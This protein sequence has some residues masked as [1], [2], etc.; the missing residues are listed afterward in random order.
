MKGGDYLGE[1]TYGCA[2]TPAPTCK[3]NVEPV[4]KKYVKDKPEL[5]KVFRKDSHTTDEWIQAKA[6]AA[7]DPT[8][9]Y[10]LYATTKCET[11]L[12]ALL[13]D[14]QANKCS[15]VKQKQKTYPM[16]G[17]RF[18]GETL[19]EY[20]RKTPLTG[21]EFIQLCIP[22]LEACVLLVKKRRIHHDLKF[23]NILVSSTTEPKIIDFGLSL[24]SSAAFDAH[25]NPYLY[26]KY[27]L[28][29]PEY[30]LYT[31][32]RDRPDQL[33]TR[34]GARVVL[35]NIFKMLDVQ[36]LSS[37]AYTLLD[38]IDQYVATCDYDQEFLSFVQNIMKH[39]TTYERIAY[40]SHSSKVDIYSLG[41]T[42]VYLSQYL[43]M[44]STP[45]SVQ[46]G[47]AELFVQMIHPNPRKRCTAKKALEMAQS[48]VLLK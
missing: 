2:F 47:L 22:L 29:P 34:A 3:G 13:K 30:V 45:A 12:K 25:G 42:L 7:I 41:I 31:Y 40:M 4:S 21:K 33:T 17:M 28:H 48:I 46:K 15:F 9:K 27:W 36:F 23:D 38:L 43:D 26:S 18:G 37:D 10:F 5:A 44:S 6:F 20:V 24:P 14:K 1:G 32:I 19:W 35:K 39:A 16:L 11:T 8:Q